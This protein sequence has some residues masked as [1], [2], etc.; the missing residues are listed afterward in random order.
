VRIIP[1]IRARSLLLVLILCAS[2]FSG[3]DK[4]LAQKFRGIV[5]FGDSLSDLGNTYNTV[6]NWITGYNSYFYDNGRWSNGPVW[7]EN[8]DRLLNLPAL[9]R[10]N[11]TNLY[12]TDFAWG[13]STTG[14]G[15]ALYLFTNLQTQVSNYIG[16]LSTP[17]AAMP[18]IS[19]TLFTVWAGGNDVIYDV[20]NIISTTPTAVS[21]NIGKSITT[22]YKAG[23]HYFLVPNL[24]PLGDKPNYLN[25]LPYHTAAN[26]FVDAY[27]PL[28]QKQIM[29]LQRNLSGAVI[30]PFDVY[31]LFRAVL[32]TPAK[33]NLS[34][35]TD[36]AFTPAGFLY[37]PASVVSNPDQY[38]FWD[39]THP[40]RVG[41]EIV[42]EAAY[43]AVMAAFNSLLTNNVSNSAPLALIAPFSA[44]A[45]D[46]NEF[47]VA[48]ALENA[49]YTSNGDLQ[50]LIEVLVMSPVSQLHA[51]FQQIDPFMVPSFSTM[52]FAIQ[53]DESSMLQQRL[54]AFG[55]GRR[56]L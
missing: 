17:N 4:A 28:L 43:A 11:G 6:S 10:N 8:L 44:F 23:G 53:T 38:L 26:Q 24:P 16:L 37:P 33:F 22:L 20:E 47:Q 56:M 7:V 40:T 39:T 18:P 54:D 46:G 52:A 30:I 51:A 19:K 15:A 12:G 9:Q 36:A 29:Q 3:I 1:F 21:Q 42:G 32:A 5:A 27:N 45:R 48:T 25:Y 49:R 50:S 55:P 2:E 14:T 41:H 35:V 34:N 31:H 13:G